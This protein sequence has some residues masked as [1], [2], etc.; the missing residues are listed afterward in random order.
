MSKIIKKN[1]NVSSARNMPNVFSLF[2]VAGYSRFTL[3]ASHMEE[4]CLTR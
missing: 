4:L 1:L 3:S 2:P